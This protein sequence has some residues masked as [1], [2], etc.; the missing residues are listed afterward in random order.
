MKNTNFDQSSSGVNIEL[1]CF[2]DNDLSRFWFNETF[3]ALQY[4]SYGQNSVLVY[5]MNLLD[6]SD[7]DLTDHENYHINNSKALILA[8]LKTDNL[9]G[10]EE[11]RDCLNYIGTSSDTIADLMLGIENYLGS[12]SMQKFLQDNFKPKFATVVSRGYCQGDYSEIIIPEKI[13]S[14]FTDQTLDTIGDYLQEEIDHLLW[15][16]PIY[17]RVQ[18]DEEEI[19]LYEDCKDL[20]EWDKDQVLNNLK[21]LDL[22]SKKKE[23]LTS[24]L[25]ANLPENPDYC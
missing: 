24:F 18:V 16:S 17:C 22:D 7:F 5:G 13:V 21:G 19:D 15:D 6:V 4:S 3:H 8:C 10:Y 25:R 14:E 23:I 11:I 1:S 2:R 9:T 20:Y 12:E